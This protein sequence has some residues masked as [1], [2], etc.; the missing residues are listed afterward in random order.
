MEADWEVTLAVPLEFTQ[1]EIDE[2]KDKH[3]KEASLLRYQ[4]IF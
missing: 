1:E 4:I 2:L 3:S